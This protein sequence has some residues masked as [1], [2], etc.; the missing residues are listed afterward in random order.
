MKKF[1]IVFAQMKYVGASHLSEQ[2]LYVCYH[3]GGGG[4]GG[5]GGGTEPPGAGGGAGI[6]IQY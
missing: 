3:A 5:G 1:T 6:S 4:G 2:G